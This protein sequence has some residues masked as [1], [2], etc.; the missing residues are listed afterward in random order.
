MKKYLLLI[1]FIFVTACSNID[2]TKE[3]FLDMAS[4]DGYILENNKQGYEKY[5]YIKNVYY[6]IERESAYDIQF[7]ELE[8]DEYAQKFFEVNKKELES[9]KTSSDYIKRINRNNYHVYHLENASKYFL[10]LQN[11]NFIIYIDAP[12]NYINEIEEFLKDLELV[13]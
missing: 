8:S 1:L 10:V 11:K 2:L 4:F 13:Y 3:K 9:V 7:I 6:A 5:D 12:I